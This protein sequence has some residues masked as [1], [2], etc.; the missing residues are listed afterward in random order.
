MAVESQGTEF[1]RSKRCASAKVLQGVD[2]IAQTLQQMMYMM[3][4][5]LSYRMCGLCAIV[6]HIKQGQPSSSAEVAN[7][8]RSHDPAKNVVVWVMA[9]RLLMAYT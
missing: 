3:S 5:V 6:S 1:P 9:C 4:V 8:Q 2:N 7:E